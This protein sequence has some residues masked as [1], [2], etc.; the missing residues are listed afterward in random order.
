MPLGVDIGGTFTDFVLLA[1][2]RLTVHKVPSTPGNH[3]LAFLQGL[4]HLGGAEVAGPIIHG[5]TIVTNT[6]LERT[7]ARTAFITTQGF[8]DLLTI[9]RQTRPLLYALE[10]QREPALVPPEL[11]FEVPERVD[12]AGQVVQALDLAAVAELSQEL[13]Q[14]QVESVAVCFLF[15]F[16]SPD[17]EQA[18]AAALQNAGFSVSASHRVLPEFREYERASATVVNAYV[19]PVFQQYLTQLEGLLPSQ[20][21]PLRVMQSNGGIVTAAAAKAAPVR[22]VLSG[23]AAGVV[24]AAYVAGLSGFFD[25][26]TFDMGGTSTDVALVP[27]RL[28]ETTE[29]TV[30]G[31]PLRVPMLDVHTVGAG[32]GSIARIDAGGALRVGPQSAGADPGPACYGVGDQPTVTDAHVVLGR[33]SSEHFLGGKMPLQTERSH[34]AVAALGRQMGLESDVAA[35][36][37]LRVANAEMGKALR[38]ISVKRGYDPRGFTLVAFGGAGPLHAC[39]LA[40]GMGITRVLVP[41]TPGVLSALGL[42][43][44]DVMKDYSQTVMW[45]LPQ[46]MDGAFVREIA[47]GFRDLAAKGWDDMHAEGFGRGNVQVLTAMDMRYVGQSYELVVPFDDLS[48]SNLAGRFHAAHRERF[49]YHLPGEPI[50]VVNLRLKLLG[51]VQRPVLPREEAGQPDPSAAVI[52]GRTVWFAGP[53]TA[54]LYDRG[55]LRAGHQIA[56][57]A[58]IVQMDATTAVPPGWAGRVDGVGS[59][60][61]EKR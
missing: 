26:I 15:S 7:G 12:A 56:G 52:G 23:P 29:A 58:L 16:L 1:D 9:G 37:I 22:I 55:L 19:G 57:P 17:H 32:G 20:G 13:R 53:T 41:R 48:T 33:L 46:V 14:L 25:L 38:V 40:E 24:G 4:E 61:L 21:V 43:T 30:A 60:I 39:E 49:G 36:G 59:L 47:M 28:R 8:K 45:R 34:Q 27:G 51:Q 44:A 3:A 2:G 6:L 50:E 42:L 11:C 35:Q 5:T 18:V 31:V 10:P 54:T